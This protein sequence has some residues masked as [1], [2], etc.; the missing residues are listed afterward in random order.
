MRTILGGINGRYLRDV[1]EAAASQTEFVE[2]AVAYANDASLLFDWCWSNQIPLR[3]W[4]R[5]DETVPVS[6]QILSTFLKRRSPN[7][8]V[9]LVRGL[10]AKAICGMA[11]VRILGLRISQMP[12]GIGTLKPDAFSQRMKFLAPS[13]RTTFANYL[14]LQTNI[15]R[16]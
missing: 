10:H 13:L 16:H 8:T 12:L 4:G 9:K 11:M 14:G 6:T 2:A 15:H 3:F 7:F 5:F 1:I